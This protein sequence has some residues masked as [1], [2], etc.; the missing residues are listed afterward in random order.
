MKG[1]IDVKKL[2]MLLDDGKTQSEI[3]KYF[4]VSKAAISKR[5]KKLQQKGIIKLS[6]PATHDKRK[7]QCGNYKVYKITEIGHLLLDDPPAPNNNKNL[8][9]IE[10]KIKQIKLDDFDIPV[11]N[12]QAEIHGYCYKAD[13]K[14]EPG[15]IPPSLKP[16]KMKHWVKHHGMFMGCYVCITTKSVRIFPKAR[17]KNYKEAKEKAEE[18]AK[19]VLAVLIHQYGWGFEPKLT[20]LDETKGAKV[21]VINLPEAKNLKS[22]SIGKLGSVDDTPEPNTVHVYNPSDVDELIIASRTFNKNK[23]RLVFKDEIERVIAEI[24]E[25]IRQNIM[26]LRIWILND[27]KD[28]FKAGYDGDVGGGHIRGYG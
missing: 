21:S 6:M 4:G 7:L 14:G 9:S 11:E 23:H 28:I 25:E 16:Q 10:K 8:I 17:G 13:L 27:F 12:I 20:V 22:P 3:A 24:K 19:K 5:I 18:K 15:S 2:L 26:N 1:K